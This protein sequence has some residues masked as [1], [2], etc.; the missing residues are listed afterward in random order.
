MRLEGHSLAPFQLTRREY[1][2]RIRVVAGVEEVLIPPVRAPPRRV[3]SETE[4]R[5]LAR[6]CECHRDRL[7]DGGAPSV[8]DPAVQAMLLL[9]QRTGLRNAALWQLLLDDVVVPGG[10]LEPRTVATANEKGGVVRRFQVD[11]ETAACLTQYLREELLPTL[12]QPWDPETVYLFPRCHTQPTQCLTAGQIHFWFRSLCRRAGVQGSHATIHGFPHFLITVLMEDK[13]NRLLDVAQFIGHRSAATTS[14]YYW[15]ADLAA[16]H[17][18]LVFPWSGGTEGG[19]QKNEGTR[20]DPHPSSTS[21]WT[22]TTDVG[23]AS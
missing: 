21:W 17:E 18:R 20:N 12:C 3:Y 15:H 4:C 8:V 16:L 9:L 14:Q 13:Q 22:P 5:A 7:G 1:G 23:L 6:A 10:A 2:R 19:K 11:T